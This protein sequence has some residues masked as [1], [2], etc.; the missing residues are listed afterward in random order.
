MDPVAAVVWVVRMAER[1][2]TR[3]VVP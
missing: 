1:M 2:V 3:K